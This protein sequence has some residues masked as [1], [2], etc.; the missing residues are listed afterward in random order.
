MFEYVSPKCRPY[1][2]FLVTTGLVSHGFRRGL[3]CNVP[4]GL[5]ATQNWS[6]TKSYG[7]WNSLADS[8]RIAVIR[9]WLIPPPSRVLRWALTMLDFA[10]RKI[11]RNILKAWGMWSMTLALTL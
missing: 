2:G 7:N 9:L 3:R 6:T 5:S 1:R 4:P 8:D 10:R 11:S